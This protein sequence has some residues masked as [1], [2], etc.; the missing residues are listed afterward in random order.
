MIKPMIALLAA[1][2][3]A[4]AQEAPQDA[5]AQSP[6]RDIAM[7]RESQVLNLMRLS[8]QA[9]MQAAELVLARAEDEAVRRFADRL[10]R[11]HQL[12]DAMVDSLA[13]SKGIALTPADF[14]DGAAPPTGARPAPPR[15]DDHFRSEDGDDLYRQ[16][17]GQSQSLAPREDEQWGQTPLDVP[18]RQSADPLE[19][20][21]DDHQAHQADERGAQHGQQAIPASVNLPQINEPPSAEQV[22]QQRQPRVAAQSEMQDPGAAQAPGASPDMPTPEVQPPRSDQTGARPVPGQT[23]RQP[24]NPRLEEDPPPPAED[25]AMERPLDLRITYLKSQRM[26]RELESADD[27]SLG[28]VYAA[29]MIKSHDETVQNLRTGLQTVSDPDVEDLLE[30]FIPILEQHAR[31]ARHMQRELG[32]QPVEVKQEG[33]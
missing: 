1:S 2:A 27:A 7:Q 14:D 33:P 18:G 11:D 16:P 32:G 20:E 19:H 29:A 21:A 26:L 30:R 25:I 31:L 24:R 22:R 5:D 4:Q 9:E 23:P 28:A 12:A 15:S 13:E 17:M 10:L 3:L 8:N 6:G